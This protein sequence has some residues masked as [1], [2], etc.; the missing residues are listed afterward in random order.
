MAERTNR[1]AAAAEDAHTSEPEA[2]PATPAAEQAA[3]QAPEAALATAAAPIETPERYAQRQPAD[4]H[5]E[6][7]TNNVAANAALRSI[8]GFNHRRLL[9]DDA[10][11]RELSV[12][13]IF[14]FPAGDDPKTTATV[15]QKVIEEYATENSSRLATHILFA[16]GQEV[17]V[18]QAK[19]LQDHYRE[20]MSSPSQS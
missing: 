17:P 5:P 15:K 6:S 10:E 16:A 1:K 14:E 9:S 18:W 2:A 3:P 13:E 8:T 11:P 7:T 12:D 19:Q 20:H 4:G